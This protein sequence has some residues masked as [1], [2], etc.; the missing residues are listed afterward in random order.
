MRDEWVR[1][2]YYTK[3]RSGMKGYSKSNIIMTHT[4]RALTR[5]S[6]RGLE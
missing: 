4:L 2:Y 6:V 3:V 1:L 5:V